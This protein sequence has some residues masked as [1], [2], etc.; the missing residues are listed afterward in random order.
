[1]T[2][3]VPVRSDRAIDEIVGKEDEDK[4]LISSQTLRETMKT[5][6]P[7]PLPPYL[8]TN[9]FRTETEKP[10]Q[11]IRQKPKPYPQELLG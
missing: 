9:V 2:K 5:D 3:R 1:M 11:K 4:R 8:I 10:C 7:F 6:I